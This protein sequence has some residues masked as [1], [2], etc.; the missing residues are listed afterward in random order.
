MRRLITPLA[1]LL[2]CAGSAVAATPAV[3]TPK[4]A[5]VITVRSVE[6]SD[7][8]D[9]R[10]PT[11]PSKGDRLLMRDDLRNVTRQFG[12]SAGAVIGTDAAILT[13]TSKTAGT[14]VGIAVLPGGR[15]RIHGVLHL[16]R[17]SAPLVVDG[18]TGRYA[19]ATGTL[20]VGAGA[21]PL[22]TYRLTLSGTNGGTTV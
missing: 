11:G 10:P 6:T 12:K 21:N 5:L 20:I 14:L 13:M 19:H 15:V 7:V 4:V 1:L 16:K 8:P 17:A 9:D 3:V 2:A 18:G 22:N